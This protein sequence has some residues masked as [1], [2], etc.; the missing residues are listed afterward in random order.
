MTTAQTDKDIKQLITN[1]ATELEA[2]VE[3][4]SNDK[5]KAAL[6]TAF[7]GVAGLDGIF[8]SGNGKGR[9]KFASR[10]HKLAS[11]KT[12]ASRKIQGQYMGALRSLTS[13]EKKKV[14]AERMK[15]GHRSAI[16]LAKKL[17][18]SHAKA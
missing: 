13:G 5:T 10:A 11:A 3:K 9:V 15:N 16:A 4:L 14:K 7:K 2:R 6:A 17:K 1:F 12:I 8:E 18:A